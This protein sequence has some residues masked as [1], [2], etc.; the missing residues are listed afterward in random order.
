MSIGEA[1]AFAGE[2]IEVGRGNFGLGVVAAEIAIA[3]IVGEDVN[4]VGAVGVGGNTGGY[5]NH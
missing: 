2:T 1:D 5:G 3:E 4:D